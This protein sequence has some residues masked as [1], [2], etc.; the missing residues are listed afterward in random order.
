MTVARAIERL[1]S[2]G[3][4]GHTAQCLFNFELDVELKPSVWDELVMA[5]DRPGARP[6]RE[7]ATE[8]FKLHRFKGF[9]IEP[10]SLHF[11]GNAVRSSRVAQLLEDRGGL[12]HGAGR[13]QVSK[14]SRDPQPPERLL[15]STPNLFDSPVYSDIMWS[16]FA[17][18][19]PE[20]CP[21]G[22]I[23]PL[24]ST[25][26]ICRLGLRWTEDEVILL[27]YSFEG[28]ARVYKPTVAD[29]CSSPFWHS[30]F[31][32]E[33]VAQRHGFTMP[34]EPCEHHERKPEVVHEPISWRGV[35]SISLIGPTERRLSAIP[36]PPMS[37]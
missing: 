9:E 10:N 29:A 33:R 27:R 32:P 36:P 23:V 15:A 37:P 2:L 3:N 24:T 20:G 28:S 11:Y 18:R 17:L 12:R 14:L 1:S 25:E 6:P 35:A 30:K 7:E 16:T 5:L 4:D 19:T 8:F 22:D 13:R 34:N 31:R 21:F 26:I